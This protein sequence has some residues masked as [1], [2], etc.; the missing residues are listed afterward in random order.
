[1]PVPRRMVTQKRPPGDKSG[2]RF[3]AWG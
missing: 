2:G 3:G 1:M